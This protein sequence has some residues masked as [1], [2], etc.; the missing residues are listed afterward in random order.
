MDTA[1]QLMDPP[2]NG[3][4]VDHLIERVAADPAERARVLRTL[5]GEA[6]CRQLGV[7]PIPAGFKL[8]VVIPVYNEEMWVRELIRRVRDVPIP[9]EI[10]V[11]DDCSKDGTRD[12]LRQLDGGDLRVIYQDVNRGKGAALREGFKHCTGDVVI[13]QDADL[14]YD[15]GEYPRLIQP[16]LDDRADVV[17]GSRFIGESHRVL[18]FWHSVANWG[19]TTL[20]NMFT[21]L[22]LTDMETC[23]KVFRREVLRGINLKSD[24]FGFEPEITA[25]VAR[26]KNPSWRVYEVPISY[27]G[28]TYEEGK[29]IGLKDAFSALYC[30]VR[31]WK[32][33]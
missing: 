27:S 25:K 8:S 3:L 24:R 16:I 22:N 15:P 18:Y 26:K 31:Y 9:K 4:D 1:V 33:D 21:N 11:V 7:Y 20:S 23:Y 28:R 12:I 13:V 19:L 30:I 17:F 10:I 29:K 5:L 6:A 2:G 32:F 14:E